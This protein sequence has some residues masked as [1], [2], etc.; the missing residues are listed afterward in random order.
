VSVFTQAYTSLNISTTLMVQAGSGDCVHLLTFVAAAV[1]QKYE[2]YF[3][4]MLPIFILT[5]IGI[6]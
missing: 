1:I 3:L 6:T 4:Q 5:H 2:I